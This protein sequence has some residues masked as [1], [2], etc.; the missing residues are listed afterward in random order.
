MSD[1]RDVIVVGGGRV[2]LHAVSLLDDLGHSC[3]V[4]E[5]DE[6]RCERIADEF[7]ATV[8]NADATDPDCLEQAGIETADVVAALTGKTG[9]NLAV[10]LLARE[11]APGIRTV[12]RVDHTR[13]GGYERFVDAIVFPERAGAR[14]AVDEIIGADVNTVSNMTG[15]VDV[16]HVR[17]AEGAPAAGKTLAEVRLPAGSIVISDQTADKVAKPDTVL[18]AGERYSVAVEPAVA[19]EVMN[20]LRG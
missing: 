18:Q 7:V 20:L 3:T 10:C 4:I 16:L 8:I 6:S 14:V 17:V 19:D 12:A 2:G 15:E 1:K 13:E 5:R 11:L 9:T